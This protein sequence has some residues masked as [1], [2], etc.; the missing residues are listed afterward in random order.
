VVC[1]SYVA[2]TTF[3]L[4]M[5]LPFLWD[6]QILFKPNVAARPVWVNIAL[7]RNPI[8]TAVLPLTTMSLCPWIGTKSM[9]SGKCAKVHS[10]R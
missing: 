9:R 6:H 5:Q 4:Y 7:K 8:F 3:L 1:L 10:N 2:Y